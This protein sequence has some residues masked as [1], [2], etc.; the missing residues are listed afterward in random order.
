MSD[1]RNSNYALYKACY[2]NLQRL[3]NKK[4]RKEIIKKVNKIYSK[5]S[6]TTIVATDTTS[7]I[8]SSDDV[9]LTDSSSICSSLSCNNTSS[10]TKLDLIL[11]IQLQNNKLETLIDSISTKSLTQI[12]DSIIN[13]M[14]EYVYRLKTHIRTLYKNDII[15]LDDIFY[16]VKIG[17]SYYE[18]G[19]SMLPDERADIAV[20][21]N[22]IIKN[23][24][25]LVVAIKQC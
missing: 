17:S 15:K 22:K 7:S 25:I 4:K 9:V 2:L 11:L 13:L 10:F 1:A 24:D 6:T 21:I 3:K 20:I 16:Q 8:C 5:L 14:T 19:Y 12:N 18:V 23:N